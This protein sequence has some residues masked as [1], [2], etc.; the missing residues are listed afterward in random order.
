MTLIGCCPDIVV[1]LT[2]PLG[3]PL[4]RL[5][6]GTWNFTR[7]LNATS[8]ATWTDSKTTVGCAINAV[9]Y[10]HNL[11]FF[12]PRRLEPL[13]MGPVTSAD[14]AKIDASDLSAWF[15]VW[16]AEASALTKIATTAS[17]KIWA[18]ILLTESQRHLPGNPLAA[19]PWVGAGAGHPTGA[20]GNF[21][22]TDKLTA[23]LAAWQTA[24]VWWTMDGRVLRFGPQGTCPPIRALSTRNFFDPDSIAVIHT[25]VAQVIVRNS[26]D[27]VAWPAQ[28][29]NRPPWQIDHVTGPDGWPTGALLRLAQAHY[30]SRSIAQGVGPVNLR[31][32]WPD[33]TVGVIAG[34]KVGLA[35]RRGSRLFPVQGWTG[36]TPPP[37]MAI[38]TIGTVSVTGTGYATT[39]IKVEFVEAPDGET[40][41]QAAVATR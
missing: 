20:F 5:V 10:W 29:T 11:A 16:I 12:H 17:L 24:G 25:A 33:L 23:V 27:R 41:A 36:A 26:T 6:G 37:P 7:A 9:P 14:D 3:R 39:D 19:I 21:A 34:R 28:P 30:A 1:C 22:E 15:D 32:C 4:R 35:G 40:A 13:W 31:R 2:D 18:G 38:G 8:T